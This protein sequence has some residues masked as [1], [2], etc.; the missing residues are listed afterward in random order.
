M[1][2]DVLALETA[3]DALLEKPRGPGQLARPKCR[4]LDDPHNAADEVSLA[5]RPVEW[6]EGVLQD[7]AVKRGC[8]V[9]AVEALLALSEVPHPT[10][11]QR[12]DGLDRANVASVQDVLDAHEF[13]GDEA[14]FRDVRVQ[15]VN[16]LQGTSF[17]PAGERLG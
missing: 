2:A 13:V 16:P 5:L 3:V 11:D 17:T 10:V 1:N 15:H 6:I 14:R 12:L 7:D 4:A 9:E 8:V